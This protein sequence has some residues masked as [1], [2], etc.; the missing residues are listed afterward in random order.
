[1]CGSNHL[2]EADR[3][4]LHFCAECMAKVCWATGADPAERA[5]VLEAFLNSAGLREDA[6]FYRT[7]AMTLKRE[8][9]TTRPGAPT[10]A[11]PNGGP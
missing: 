3:R 11:R 8:G 9:P 4:P 1:M 2:A 7:A 5:E 10:D 6:D